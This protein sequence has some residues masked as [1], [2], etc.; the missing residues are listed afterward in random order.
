MDLR[1]KD[2]IP[3]EVEYVMKS[4]MDAGYE[5]YLVGGCVRDFLMGLAP[6]DFDVTTNAEPEE[7][8]EVFGASEERGTPTNKE[9]GIPAD[10]EQEADAHIIDTGL[11]HGTVTV[12]RNHIPVEVTTYRTES[13]YSDGRHPDEVKFS[14]SLEEDLARRDFTMNAIAYNP[15]QESTDN[16]ELG[17]VVDPYNGQVD[18]ENR[19]IRCVGNP[20][21]RF[22]EDGLRIMRA[23]RFSSVLGFEVEEATSEALFSEKDRLDV[24]SRERIQKELQGILCGNDVE[25][26]LRDYAEVI[27]KV[28]PEIRPMIGFDQKNKYHIYDVWEHTLRVVS[29]I[30]GKPELRLAALFHDIGKPEC[31]TLD[32]NG[33]GHFYGHPGVSRKMADSIMRRLKFDNKTREKVLTLVEWHDLRPSSTDR[34]VRKTLA[35]VGEELFLDWLAL[36]RADNGAQ[37][38]LAFDRRSQFDEVEE[39]GRRLIETEGVISVKTLEISGEDLMNLGYE[40]GPELGEVLQRLLQ[41]V[42]DGEIANNREELLKRAESFLAR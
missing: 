33:V 6:K 40:S 3:K 31:F 21:E 13:T 25:R 14:K 17:L 12:V 36:K 19:V 22:A 42:L 24:V 28:I 20:M 32:E 2:I 23:L 37:S 30:P 29:G 5:A 8:H 11:K 38:H 16:K 7:V 34:S 26:V 27:E 4:L 9:R 35:R 18:I 41:D 15:F 1:M 39:I 10:N